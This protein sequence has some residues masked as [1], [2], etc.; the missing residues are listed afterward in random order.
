[1]KKIEIIGFN[2]SY[3]GG[4]PV[5]RDINLEI[6]RGFFGLIGPSGCGKSTLCLALNGLIPH[7][8]AGVKTGKV[9]VCGKDTDKYHT[10]QMARH[11]GMVFQNPESQLFSLCAEDEIAFGPGNFGV[12][13]REIKKRVA[14]AIKKLKM[15]HLK[16]KSPEQMSSGEQQKTAIA[17]ALAMHPADAGSDMPILEK[18]KLVIAAAMALDPDILVLDEPSANLDPRSAEEIFAILKKI[19]QEKII[20]LVSHNIG[21]IFRYADTVAVMDRGAIVMCGAPADILNSEKLLDYLDLPAISELSNEL[22][23]KPMALVAEDIA[24]KIKFSKEVHFKSKIVYRKNPVVKVDDIDFEYVKGAPILQDISLE[25]SRG[26]FLAIVGNNGSGKSTLALN[27]IGIL[28]P[29]RGNIFINGK[30]TK[31]E[32]ISDLVRSIGYAFQNPD[33]QIFEDTLRQEVAFGLKNLHLPPDEITKKTTDA[34]NYV[35]LQEYAD[36]DPFSLSLGQ[37]RRLTIASILAMGPKIIILDEPT[38]GIDDRIVKSLMKLIVRLNRE[39]HTVI[40]MI[41]HNMDLTARYAERVVVLSGGRIISDGPV[42]KIFAQADILEKANLMR[43]EINRLGHILGNSE[44]LTTD[45]VLS[46]L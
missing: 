35:G 19:S 29:Q 24:P 31:K 30:N 32:K 1:M 2:F 27:M 45:D 3:S 17:A 25:I 9:I 26:E 28:K 12:S 38:T 43:P 10:R 7:E 16:N 18:E 44:V 41:T 15:E 11:V 36:S 33:L 20:F 14:Q 42:R 6:G 37:K 39:G 21:Q 34:L 13:W 8:I 40:N 5:L 22:R 23:L 4:K 46:L